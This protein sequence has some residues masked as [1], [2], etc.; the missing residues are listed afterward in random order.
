ML[1]CLLEKNE[2][3]ALSNEKLGETDVVKH[4][5]DM[6]GAKLVKEAQRRLP[7]ALRQQLEL[8]LDELLKIGCIEPANSSY[9][10]PFVLVRNTDVSLRL[11]VDYRTINK[12]TIPD[13]YPLPHVDELIN[14]IGA[15]KA[16]YLHKLK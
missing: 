13:Q 5:L 16:V 11:C 6:T 7:Y 2:A 8:E 3:F 10:S 12:D 15:Q 1:D 9:A 14:A 4:S